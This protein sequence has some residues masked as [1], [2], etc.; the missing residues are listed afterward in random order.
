M[1]API[2]SILISGTSACQTARRML[3]CTRAETHARTVVRM[4]QQ[5]LASPFDGWLFI[6][7][8]FENGDVG[9]SPPVVAVSQDVTHGFWTLSRYFRQSPNCRHKTFF[10][11]VSVLFGQTVHYVQMDQIAHPQIRPTMY[12]FFYR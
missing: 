3:R 7:I 5:Q 12:V 1:K 4:P 11:G 9:I 6:F 10:G 8:F 2:R